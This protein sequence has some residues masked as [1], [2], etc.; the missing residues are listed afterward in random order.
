VKQTHAALSD[1]QNGHHTQHPPSSQPGLPSFPAQGN[2][3]VPPSPERRPHATGQSHLPSS[4]P[5]RAPFS[6]SRGMGAPSSMQPAMGHPELPRMQHMQPG[7]HLPGVG[8]FARPSS[9]H[10]GYGPVPV[11]PSM[12]PT[13]GNR[14]VGP[15]V[16][17]PHAAPANGSAAVPGNSSFDSYTTPRP[18]SGYGGTPTMSHRYPSFST[19]GT[20][21]GGHSSPPHSSHGMGMSG[22]SPTKQSPRPMTSAGIT[23]A[24]VLPPIRRLEPS[25][26]LMGRS[27]PDAPIPPPMKCM[28][29]EQEE[30]RQRENASIFQQNHVY[31][32]NGQPA[33]MS[34]PSMNHIPS[35]GPAATSPYPEPVPSPQH[36]NNVPHQ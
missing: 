2:F 7:P 27:S 22:I 1:A 28:T 8:S 32:G 35:L 14:D 13:Q 26:K 12:S 23:A 5:P 33:L 17:L 9:S 10:S 34:S 31:S 16:G 19:T 30:R 6:P 18:H 4:S 29:P 3:Y 36:G 25:P 20:P 11:Q 24:P 21:N 15:I